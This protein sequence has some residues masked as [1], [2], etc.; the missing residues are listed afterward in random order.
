MRSME[1]RRVRRQEGKEDAKAVFSQL[2]SLLS[3]PPIP[4]LSS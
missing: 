1:E 4:P 2:L 3:T